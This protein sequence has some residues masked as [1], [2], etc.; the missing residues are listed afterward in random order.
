MTRVIKAI[1][2]ALTA[3]RS[4]KASRRSLA[5]TREALKNPYYADEPSGAR[6]RLEIGY[7]R[8]APIRTEQTE[9]HMAA[10]LP[11]KRAVSAAEPTRRLRLGCMSVA[12]FGITVSTPPTCRCREP[13]QKPRSIYRIR[14]SPQVG[15]WRK[16]LRSTPGHCLTGSRCLTRSPVPKPSRPRPSRHSAP[17]VRSFP[18]GSVWSRSK[19]RH[20]VFEHWRRQAPPGNQPSR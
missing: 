4:R 9:I 14:H 1:L 20:R 6:P 8:S 15:R 7:R 12:R 5:V 3:L 13:R 16:R 10:K 18:S 19:F 17:L 2:P 11:T